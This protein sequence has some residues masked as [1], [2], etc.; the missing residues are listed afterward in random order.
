VNFWNPS[1]TL[2]VLMF[3]V[4]DDLIAFSSENGENYTL[5]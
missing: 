3:G 5:L 4:I 2:E 1:G